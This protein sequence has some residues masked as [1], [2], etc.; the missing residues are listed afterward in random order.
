M[1]DETTAGEFTVEE[2]KSLRSEIDTAR[3]KKLDYLVNTLSRYNSI[4][5]LPIN[6]IL[7]LMKINAKDTWGIP[8][9]INI[10]KDLD[11]S[12]DEMKEVLDLAKVARITEEDESRPTGVYGVTGLGPT[13]PQG[14][15]GGVIE[16]SSTGGGVI[17]FSSTGPQIGIFIRNQSG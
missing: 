10:C 2:L 12:K 4:L 9:I 8:E 11:L 6:V 5:N 14:G 1:L 16:F 17:G 7:R 3:R 15:S 13:D